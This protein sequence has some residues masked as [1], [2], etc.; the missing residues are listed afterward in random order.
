MRQQNDEK[1]VLKQERDQMLRLVS[2]GFYNELINY[3]VRKDEILRVAS[4]LLDNLMAQEKKP[5][6]GVQYYNH[7]FTLDTVKDEWKER[8]RLTVQHVT[9]RPLQPTVISKVVQWLKNPAIRESFVPAFPEQE[10]DLQKYFT[11]PTRDYFGIYYNDQPVGIVGGENIDPVAGKLEMKKLVGESGLQGKGIGKRATFGFL[12]Y[13]FLIL[14][15]N[16]VYI[17]SRDINIHNLNLNSRFGFELEG[18]FFEDIKVGDK[19]Q[20]IVRMALFKSLWLQVFSR[21]A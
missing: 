3:G 6:E 20:D 2:K 21:A 1:T 9:L 19:R 10:T 15:L 7:I 14:D 11:H 17:H 5:G 16:K 4:H 13:A 12:Y 8:K 18:I